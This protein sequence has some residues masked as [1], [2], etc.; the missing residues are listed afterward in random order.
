MSYRLHYVHDVTGIRYAKELTCA[1]EAEALRVAGDMASD[2][3][4]ELWREDRL[5][6]RFPLPPEKRSLPTVQAIMEKIN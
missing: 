5:I 6:K 1:S 4:V 2:N 3:H